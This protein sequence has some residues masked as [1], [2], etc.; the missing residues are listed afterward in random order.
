MC[1]VSVWSFQSESVIR[2]PQV[3]LEKNLAPC[4][5]SPWHPWFKCC[6]RSGRK[7]NPYMVYWVWS[8]RDS[9]HLLEPE[10]LAGK[11]RTDRKVRITTCA[12]VCILVCACVWMRV[13]CILLVFV[14]ECVLCVLHKH[15]EEKQTFPRESCWSE[16]KVWTLKK[17][18]KVTQDYSHRSSLAK[19]LF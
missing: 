8:W 14:N 2:P 19:M 4:P 5:I 12:C 17:G 13:L 10:I 9:P 11:H 1:W 3:S 16:P 15:K 18:Y 6:M 7:S